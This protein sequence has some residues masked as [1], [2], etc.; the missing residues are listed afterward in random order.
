MRGC[1]RRVGALGKTG[2]RSCRKLLYRGCLVGSFL[3]LFV[4]VCGGG[5]FT[6]VVLSLPEG[7]GVSLVLGFVLVCVMLLFLFIAI[8]SSMILY[9][10]FCCWHCEGVCMLLS[11][12]L[13]SYIRT[14][15]QF[16]CSLSL[17]FVF[18][19]VRMSSSFLITF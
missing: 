16:S 5:G 8:F 18:V 12:L 15:S 4:V 7:C 17:L 2:A 14:L 6:F 1:R 9:F 10:Q 3:L 13:Q 19:V 11:P